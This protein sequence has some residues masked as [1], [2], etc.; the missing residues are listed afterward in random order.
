MSALAIVDNSLLYRSEFQPVVVETNNP[1]ICINAMQTVFIDADKDYE[2]FP[3]ELDVALVALSITTTALVLAA[4]F[5]EF[6]GPYVVEGL[7]LL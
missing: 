4:A 1:C 7:P 6:I 2:W 5:M 3:P